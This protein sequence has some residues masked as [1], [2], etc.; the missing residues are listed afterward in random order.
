MLQNQELSN[1]AAGTRRCNTIVTCYNWHEMLPAFGSTL[2]GRNFYVSVERR[3]E[4]GE[5][6]FGEQRPL[7]S[8]E[9][10]KSKPFFRE[11]V[12]YF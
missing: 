10:E 11:F 3:A 7:E 12:I 6:R 8:G 4:S 1:Q 5:R 2:D 9:K